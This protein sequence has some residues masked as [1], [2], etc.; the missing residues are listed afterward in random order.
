M[1]FRN[2]FWAIVEWCSGWDGQTGRMGKRVNGGGTTN[3]YPLVYFILFH[4]K[5]LRHC[6][7][8]SQV[9]SKFDPKNNVNHF[10]FILTSRS[11]IVTIYFQKVFFR[12]CFDGLAFHLDLHKYQM[13]VCF[14]QMH[15]FD[16]FDS[17]ATSEMLQISSTASKNCWEFWG[18]F[19]LTYSRRTLL[20]SVSSH[21][22]LFPEEYRLKM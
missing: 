8:F 11:S 3:G 7:S 4:R 21:S 14:A 1:Q 19:W 2:Y 17:I 16:G 10:H 22:V 20:I 18:K 9:M 6:W 5:I 12:Q 15:K 13:T